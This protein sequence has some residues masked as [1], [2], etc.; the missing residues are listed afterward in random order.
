MA[1]AKKRRRV[2]PVSPQLKPDRPEP[3]DD[4]I[5]F[6]PASRG[7]VPAV[8]SSG[9]V[10]E[11]AGP[12]VL[13]LPRKSPN[14]FILPDP[15]PKGHVLVDTRKRA[16]QLGDSIGLG[17]FGEI[18]AA[19]RFRAGPGAHLDEEDFVIKVEPHSNGPLFVEIAFYLRAAQHHQLE[20]Q[21]EARGW[22]HLGLAHFVASGSLVFNGKRLRFLVLPRF[23]MDLQS[24]ID[25]SSGFSFATKTACSMASQV[26]DALEYIHRQGYVHKDIKGSNLLLGRTNLRSKV[27]LVDFGLCSQFRQNGVHKPEIP[28]IRWAHEGTLEYTS[29]DCHLGCFS[30]R[31]DLE[32]LFYNLIEWLGGRLPWDEL[33]QM[34]PKVIQAQKVEAFRD[35]PAF[36]NA[37]YPDREDGPPALLKRLMTTI[38]DMEFEEEPDYSFIRSLL[39]REVSRSVHLDEVT[40]NIEMKSAHVNDCPAWPTEGKENCNPQSGALANNEHPAVGPAEGPNRRRKRVSQKE[41]APAP[42]KPRIVPQHSFKELRE[43]AI[44]R[45]C[46]WSLLNPTPAMLE[47]LE[48][49]RARPPV[50]G[51]PRMTR[52]QKIRR[53]KSLTPSPSTPEMLAVMAKRDR[54]PKRGSKKPSSPPA[55]RSRQTSTRSRQSSRSSC[56]S[57]TSV[58]STA[59]KN[60]VP[61]ARRPSTAM[62]PRR[63]LFASN[64]QRMGRSGADT[65]SPKKKNAVTK[66][67]RRIPRHNTMPNL[68]SHPTA[69]NGVGSAALPTQSIRSQVSLA[70]EAGLGNISGFFAGVSRTLFPFKKH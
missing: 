32:V 66:S 3:E 50:A 54:T 36:L 33:G 63:R 55:T 6:K 53:W 24:I 14:G 16:W 60:T 2:A 30:R 62:T 43:L 10:T 47:R 29:R 4:E 69:M 21:R 7:A 61:L 46:E 12:L 57:T 64:S 42:K 39:K 41:D 19:Q 26:L 25:S 52:H 1:P 28:D 18:Y 70:M 22:D 23:G 38:H 5:S 44:Q 8:T 37:C 20:A 35:H 67:P 51:T 58:G 48:I 56:K 65:L 59:K 17:G 31:G 68:R 15:L 27:F 9:A 13:D 34:H 49:M 11:A 40:L 45:Q